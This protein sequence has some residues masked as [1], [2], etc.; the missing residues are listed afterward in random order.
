MANITWDSTT[1]SAGATLSPG[2]LTTTMAISTQYVL[3]T[4][5]QTTG[6]YYFEVTFGGAGL[7]NAVGLIKPGAVPGSTSE[8]PAA[9]NFQLIST[10][11]AAV[12][13]AGTTLITTTAYGTT[14]TMAAGTVLCC[15]VDFDNQRIWFRVG[16]TANWNGTVAGNPATNTG[17]V[18]LALLGANGISLVPYLKT[19]T[20]QSDTANFGDTAF[21][22]T[23]PS[24]FTSGFPTGGASNA[25][26]TQVGAEVWR[27]APS[28][29]QFT[30]I[31]AEV[32]RS[33][34]TVEVTTT[35]QPIV[36]MLC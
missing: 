32:W 26:I 23:V 7:P 24:G 17:G 20:A 34:A 27:A 19:A 15:A 6:K 12:T 28:N 30:Q 10:T 18:S 4:T 35:P 16:P 1:K 5:G 8:L 13:V 9:V 2:N 14:A 25:L 21:S 11:T 33:V 36:M 29:A 22:G 3:G 31:G